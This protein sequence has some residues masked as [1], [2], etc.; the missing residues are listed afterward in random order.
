MVN[1]NL[2]VSQIKKNVLKKYMM[3]LEILNIKD[4]IYLAHFSKKIY[5][6][7]GYVDGDRGKDLKR[8]TESAPPPADNFPVII[9]H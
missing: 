5:K 4:D 3:N 8:G 2:M 7:G 6:H 1:Y 9:Q